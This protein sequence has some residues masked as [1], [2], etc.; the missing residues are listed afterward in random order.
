L[1]SNA[2]PQRGGILVENMFP[3]KIKAPEGRHKMVYA[4]RQHLATELDSAI[5]I[6]AA[7]SEL[8]YIPHS[9]YGN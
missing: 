7:P 2:K 4:A 1:V 3:N 8:M 5:K 9:N 6:Y